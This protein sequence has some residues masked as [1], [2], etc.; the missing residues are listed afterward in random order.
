MF[1][2]PVSECL[3]LPLLILLCNYL[4]K[5]RL[6]SLDFNSA[7]SCF[8]IHC[9]H[10][11]DILGCFLKVNNFIMKALKPQPV[12]GIFLLPKLFFVLGH[13]LCSSVSKFTFGLLA[14]SGH[15]GLVACFRQLLPETLPTLRDM[16]GS[17]L[18]VSV[19]FGALP[20]NHCTFSCSF[21]SSL[22][23]QGQCVNM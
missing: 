19:C 3:F 22:G 7:I 15:E 9:N 2:F 5:K 21:R 23:Q 14:P 16:S 10:I 17:S 6:T 4:I 20:P 11:K 1:W 8:E 18:E 13:T 12:F